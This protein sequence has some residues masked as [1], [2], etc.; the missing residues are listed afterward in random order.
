M[1]ETPNKEC[2]IHSFAYE[3]KQAQGRIICKQEDE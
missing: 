3:E 2:E 1:D